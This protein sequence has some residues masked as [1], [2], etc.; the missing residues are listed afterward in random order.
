MRSIDWMDTQMSMIS[1][2]GLLQVYWLD[3]LILGI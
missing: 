1:G 2:T 3:L